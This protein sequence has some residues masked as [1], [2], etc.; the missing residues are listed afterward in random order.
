VAPPNE[1]DVLAPRT[2]VGM[3]GLDDTVLLKCL[4]SAGAT[5]A[6]VN[7]RANYACDD[8]RWLMGAPVGGTRVMIVRVPP[9]T[10]QALARPDTL[11]A[12]L[13]WPHHREFRPA[14]QAPSTSL[15]MTISR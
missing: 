7:G 10:P 2:T 12:Q 13:A 1:L 14:S 9:L 11:L 4:Y 6:S 5:F 8:G 3:A 15:A